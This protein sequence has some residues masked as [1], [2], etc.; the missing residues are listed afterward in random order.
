M[1]LKDNFAQAMRELTG[2]GGKD[3]KSVAGEFK[4]SKEARIAGEVETLKRKTL[5]EESELGFSAGTP[6]FMNSSPFA[7]DGTSELSGG[8]AGYGGFTPENQLAARSDTDD[9]VFGDAS[10]GSVLLPETET[11]FDGPP[12]YG[13]GDEQPLYG[14]DMSDTTALPVVSPETV[15]ADETEESAEDEDDAAIDL[16]ALRGN[17][18]FDGTADAVAAPAPASVT[19]SETVIEAAPAPTAAPVSEPV[20]AP[21]PVQKHPPMPKQQFSPSSGLGGYGLSASQDYHKD[22]QRPDFGRSAAS[23]RYTGG[24]QY[25]GGRQ[26]AP[27]ARS[28]GRPPVQ[29]PPPPRSS[30]GNP[31]A[32]G[33]SGY[34]GGYGMQG[35]GPG[36]S[37]GA[38][39]GSYTDDS[40][41]T[42][43][44]KNTVI[45]GDMS[46]FANIAVD[47]DVKGNIE[48]TKNID[49]NGKIVGDVSCN[50]A[51]MHTAL[52]QGNVRM[53]G[54]VLMERDSLLMGDI[55]ATYAEINGKVKGN[56]NIVGKA[57][58]RDDA[59]VKGDIS[60]S[61]LSVADGA[62]I[63]GYVSTTFMGKD[64]SSNIFPEQVVIDTKQ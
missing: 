17:T 13:G 34:N 8:L 3:G 61:T 18:L 19:V 41:I 20:P 5:T 51:E 40:E 39:Q 36:G 60:V 33:G 24:A 1:G 38:L 6:A 52:I 62:I 46:S 59:V 28:F 7:D 4:E 22:L 48:T 16:S 35:G 58:F 45:T 23:T 12:M 57:E 31:A 27:P 14:G 56:L 21:V 53:K 63:Q 42:I 26:P 29:V 30:Y 44:S 64:E 9:A 54:N 32:F 55:S 47:G 10:G 43:I 37:G 49:L 2:V 11:Y 15:T 25:G 50:N